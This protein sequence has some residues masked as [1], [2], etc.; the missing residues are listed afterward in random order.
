[1]GQF[2]VEIYTLP[3]SVL[4][5]NQQPDGQVENIVAIGHRHPAPV[6]AGTASAEAAITWAAVGKLGLVTG[7]MIPGPVGTAFSTGLAV[8]QWQSGDKSGALVTL[9]LGALNLV[10]VDAAA[11]RVILG[12]KETQAAATAAR[13][14]AAEGR[15]AATASDT[16]QTYEK[17]SV[18][19]AQP[20]LP[21]GYSWV[22]NAEGDLGIKT[23]EG[24]VVS[25]SQSKKE[26]IGKNPES[27]SNQEGVT[28]KASNSRN[29]FWGTWKDY[30]KVTIG[31]R[32]YAQIGGRNYSRHAVDRMQPSGLGT[33]VGAD[34]P[35]RNV[36]PNMVEDIINGGSVRTTTVN[37]VP[38]AIYTSGN[39]SVVT[40]DAGRT[41]VTI[42]RNS[43]P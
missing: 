42:L 27:L 17:G 24:K 5:E 1:M 41:I 35:G 15:A 28:D 36:T 43:S 33:P 30:T 8:V 25:D 29:L 26:I 23:P 40:E 11:G 6:P 39:V 34:G 31:G 37:G 3:G 14:V 20:S 18:G 19:A 38:R 32:E 22:K 9:G 4:G 10:G 21:E 12:M 13:G 7:S 16:W 2:S